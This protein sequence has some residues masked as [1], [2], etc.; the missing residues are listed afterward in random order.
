MLRSF[1]DLTS[2]CHWAYTLEDHH[3]GSHPAC[4][5]IRLISFNRPARDVFNPDGV[6]RDCHVSDI[7]RKAGG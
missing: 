2:I 6:T 3:R 5:F 7:D 1:D 4:H